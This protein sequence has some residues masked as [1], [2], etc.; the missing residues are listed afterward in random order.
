MSSRALTELLHGKGAHA[1][2]VACV[3]DLSAELAARQVEGFPHSIGQLVFH[4]NYWMDY[5][6]RRIRG[7]KPA[8]PEHNSE[9]FPPTPSPAD[10]QEWDRLRKN[11]TSLLAD[12][13]ALADSS[14]QEMRRQIET[15]HEGDA[16]V[17]G[18]LEAVLWQMVAHNSYHTGQIALIRRML[19]AW[20][21]TG[22]GD[23]W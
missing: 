18:T 10:A 20:P 11:F 12:F 7:Q 5:E 14:P 19:G 6:L 3:E 16:K 13:A 15:V 2:P 22:G 4:M 17:A 9:S 1:D 8:Y 21:P 23:T